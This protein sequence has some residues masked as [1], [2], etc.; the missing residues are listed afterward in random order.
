MRFEKRL[1]TLER[2][3]LPRE[4]MIIEVNR[5][6]AEETMP[7]QEA[8]GLPDN[9]REWPSAALALLTPFSQRVVTI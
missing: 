3:L 8:L 1:E 6:I 7:L 2:Q 9:L 4:P 5:Y